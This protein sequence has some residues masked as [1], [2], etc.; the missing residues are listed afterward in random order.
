MGENNKH[1]AKTEVMNVHVRVDVY[2]HNVDDEEKV[3]VTNEVIDDILEDVLKTI[4]FGE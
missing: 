2:H 4:L 1:D 3:A